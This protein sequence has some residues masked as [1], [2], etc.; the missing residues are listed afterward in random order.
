MSGKIWYITGTSRGFGR[1]WATAALLRG[2]KVA[3]TAR[4]TSSLNALVSQ[5]GDAVL[6]IKLDVTDRSASFAAIQSAHEHFGRLDVVVNNAGYGHFGFVEE[7]AEAEVRAQLETNLFGALWTTQ[8]AIPLLR[9]QGGGHILQISSIGG[10]AAFPS[11]GIYHASKWALEGLT[12][13]LSAEVAMFGIRTTL[14]EPGGYATD[15]AGDSAHRSAPLPQYK[16]VVDAM[17]ARTA[18]TKSPPASATVAAILALVDAA[19]PPKRLLL[20]SMAY[21]TAAA[22][23]AQRIETWH[24]WEPISRAADGQ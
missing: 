18:H 20:G 6:P 12:E 13:A 24:A 8:A 1:E 10:V 22:V 21:D 19:E 9:G 3:A 23:Y 7:L 4:D 14:V 2:D 15:W 11:L 17:I 16:P 5:F